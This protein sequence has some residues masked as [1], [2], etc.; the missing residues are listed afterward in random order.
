MAAVLEMLS[1]RWQGQSTHGATGGI[2]QWQ[3]VEMMFIRNDND[4]QI[5]ISGH[6]ISL[7]H[8][9]SIPF[10]LSGTWFTRTMK[11]LLH[12]QHTDQFTDILDYVCHLDVADLQIIGQSLTSDLVLC[13]QTQLTTAPAPQ[14][15]IRPPTDV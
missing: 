7:W 3:D 2:T 6:G 5:L 4:E 15:L 9:R 12:K 14:S 1:G 13:K 8:N 10:I 11:L